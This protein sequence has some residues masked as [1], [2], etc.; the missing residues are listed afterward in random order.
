MVLCIQAY[1]TR[2][3]LMKAAQ[4][5]S[6]DLRRDKE[7]KGQRHELVFSVDETQVKFKG[8][9][10]GGEGLCRAEELAMGSHWRT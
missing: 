10:E 1:K 8:A 3:R 5:M 4:R 9:E 6:G 2:V 7:G